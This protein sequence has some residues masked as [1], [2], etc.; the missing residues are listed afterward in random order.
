MDWTIA[1]PATFVFVG[2]Y[3]QIAFCLVVLAVVFGMGTMRYVF[4][5]TITSRVG[6]CRSY[7][8]WQFSQ[9]LLCGSAPDP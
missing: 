5:A 4:A 1:I 7:C 2:G 6:F 3:D 8:V 9:A